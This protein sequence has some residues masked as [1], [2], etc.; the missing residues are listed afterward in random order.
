M[1]ICN[2]DI[3]GEPRD[4]RIA[5]G[6]IAE[7][8]RGLNGPEMYDGQGGALLP[9][10]HDHHIHLNASA[11][12]L[13]S[14][15]CGPP[16]VKSAEELID[17]L[18]Q[19]GEGM[20]RGIG[21]HHSVA[22]E[23]D[24]AWLDANGPERPVRIQHRGGRMWIFNSPA[25]EAFGLSEPADGRLVDGDTR[26]RANATYPDLEPL[27]R[28]LHGFGITGVTEVT[29]SNGVSEFHHYVETVETLRLSIMGRAELAG[30]D[31]TRVGPLKLHYHDYNL[32]SLEDLS[33][34]IATSHVRE[35][36]IAAHCV[37]RAE[38]MLTLAALE[39]AGTMQG[40]RIEHAAIADDAAIEW[41]TRLAVTV[42]TQPGF[43]FERQ[44]AYRKDVP[45]NDHK[46]LWRLAAFQ[47]A[48]LTMAAGSD[49]PFGGVNP[50]KAMDTAVNRPSGFGAGEALTPEAALDLYLKPTH[51]AFEK[52]RRIEVGHPADLCLL[53]QPWA[54]ARKNLSSVSVKATWVAGKQV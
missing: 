11:A 34:E 36:P 2:V 45:Q 16:E 46:N 15:M 7:I 33:A 13:N 44:T 4:V 17:A 12:A 20:I 6:K 49:A 28:M 53:T 37:T 10:L 19:P 52:P 48:G 30:I 9:G 27:I 32:P 35:R 23:I 18:N 22:G 47:K 54:A 29:P 31:D 14:V 21:Y 24:R 41:M 25:M 38:L 42:V 39:E 8:G 50:W 43:L 40:D 5:N 1:L 26:L 51:A 3:G